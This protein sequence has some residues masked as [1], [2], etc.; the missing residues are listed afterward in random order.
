MTGCQNFSQL[1]E[2]QTNQSVN[3]HRLAMEFKKLASFKLDYAPQYHI[4]KYISP[5]TKLQLVH[6][7]HKSSPLVQGYFAVATECPT[8][9]GTPHTLEHL[10]FMGSNTYP[11]KGF[12]DTAGNLCM[13]STN[14]W[15]ATDQTVYTLTSAGWTGFKK[16]LPVYLDHILNPTLT[17]EACMTEVHHV[18]PEDLSDKGVV[19]SE[20]DAIESQSWFVTMLERQK[21]MFPEGSGY[22]S[23]TGGLTPNLRTLT[24]EEIKK[25]HHELYASNNLCLIICGNTPEEELLEIVGK[26]NATL[27][28]IDEL[29]LKRPFLDTPASHIPEKRLHTTQS[30]VEFPELDESQSEIL[31]SWIGERHTDYENDLAVSILLEYF[32]ESAL[33]PFTKELVEIEDPLANS[34]DYWTDDFMRSIISIGVHGVPTEKLEETKTKVLDILKTHEI[35]LER[36]QQVVDNN[37]WEYVLRVEK[38]GDSALSQAAITDFLYGNPDGSTLVESLK[39]MADFDALAKWDVKQWDDLRKRI[40]IDNKPVIVLGKPSSQLYDKIEKDS[41][42]FIAK[43][44]ADLPSEEVEK[45]KQNLQKAIQKNENPIPQ[46]LLAKFEIKDPVKSVDFIKTETINTS[47]PNADGSEL[48]R[49]VM[50]SKPE[51]FPLFLY[52]EHFT[53]QFVEFHCILD[54]TLIK[55]TTMLPLY[56]IFNELFSMP[57][58]DGDNLIPFEE[59]VSKLKTDTVDYQISLGMQGNAP[60]LVDFKIRCKAD[61]YK[62]AVNWIKHALFDMVF[63]ESRVSILLE[64]Y[65]NS[66]VELKR[67]GDIMLD[68]LCSRTLYTERSV[69]KSVDPLFVES[70]LE[71]VL[72]LIENGQYTKEILPKLE[73]FRSQLTKNFDKFQ[74]IVFGDIEKIGS[75]LFKPWSSLVDAAKLANA[76]PQSSAHLVPSIPRSLDSITDLCASPSSKAFV[77]TT[78]A[79]ESSYMNVITSIPFNMNYDHPDYAVV[80]LASEYL[81]CVEGPFWKGI[82]GA[83]LAYGANMLKM[84][85]VN[86]WGFNIYRGSDVVKCY[87]AAKEIVNDYATGKIELDKQ[88]IQGAVSSIINRIATVESGYFAAASGKFADDIILKRGADFTDRYLERLNAVS[89]QDLQRVL[90]KYF[91]NLFEKDKSIIFISCHPTKLNET[92]EFLETHGFSVELEELEEES[93]ESEDESD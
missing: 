74:I 44:K 20:M 51:D 41:Q 40:L 85:E 25:F 18:D 81:Q 19:Y 38:N 53:S 60:D 56:H 23:E 69:K 3:I 49:N 89:V 70:K 73:S 35:D 92:R 63:D 65:L 78:P 91:L 6:V 54:S 34:A 59:V 7:H 31:M 62:D 8:D 55:D 14:A 82:R 5:R 80:S 43:R 48:M 67:E 64:N 24:N 12:L 10:V 21:Q 88:L 37:K 50:A 33:A 15:T 36:M 57:M 52:A 1:N 75:N 28:D 90:G 39:D 22:R 87:E 86:C 13:S 76:T 32:T 45:M 11:Y 61:K 29:T 9:S 83:G 77:I 17:D 26:W 27:P 16:L 72:D 4:S 30:E 79:S 71:E 84:V 66:I 2:K 46:D 68:S 93:D 47:L 58:M 42:E